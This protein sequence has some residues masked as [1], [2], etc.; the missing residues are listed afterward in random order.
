[1][2]LL[3]A[4]GNESKICNMR[5]RLM[6]YDVELVTPRELGIQ[7]DVD[8]T[9]TTPIENARLKATAYHE[10]TGLPT[11]AADSG[12]YIDGIPVEAQP[13]LYVHRVNGKNLTDDEMISH[14]SALAAQYGGKLN[15]RYITGLVL[16]NE[17]KEHTTE[18]PD[19]DFFI[20]DKPND[21]RNHRGNPLDVIVICPANGKYYNDCSLDELAQIAGSFDKKCISFLQKSKII[22]EKSCGAIV[23]TRENGDLKYLLVEEASGFH[24]FPKGHIEIGETEEETAVREIKEETDLELSLITGFREISEYVPSERPD[25]LR[26]VV[27]FLAEYGDQCPKVVNPHEVRSLKSLDLQEA[28]E[29]L[30]YDNSRQLLLL[31]D[32]YIAEHIK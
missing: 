26:Q 7:I 10:K 20:S 14:Y 16:I 22:P 23:Y 29:T 6:G 9:G 18:I 31:A 1:M 8:E 15:A 32:K 21:N 11:L 25:V 2:R 27:Y 12:L 30:E 3:Y 5:Y 4:T 13:G 17:G 19:D 24:S 28:L